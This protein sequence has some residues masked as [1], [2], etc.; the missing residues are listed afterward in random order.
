MQETVL[1]HL[2]LLGNSGYGKP[3]SGKQTSFTPKTRRQSTEPC[4]ARISQILTRSGRRMSW[5]VESLGSQS[6]A[7]FRLESLSISWQSCGCW[8][9]IT[10]SLTGILTEE[11]LS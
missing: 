10:T 1:S 3:W 7:H 8:N 5:K 9:S 11:I 4:E 2:K 6:D